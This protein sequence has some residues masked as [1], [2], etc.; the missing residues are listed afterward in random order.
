[1][2]GPP[3]DLPVE[4]SLD[5][6]EESSSL[7]VSVPPGTTT[8]PLLESVSPQLDPTS[9][10]TTVGELSPI[11]VMRAMHESSN[12]ELH[13]HEMKTMEIGSG[14]VNS[15]NC[16]ALD[17]LSWS[18]VTVEVL[19]S[20]EVRYHGVLAWCAVW[21]PGVYE[22][23]GVGLGRPNMERTRLA[24]M[25]ASSLRNRPL[26]FVGATA[27]VAFLLVWP[28]FPK[29]WPIVSTSSPAAKKPNTSPPTEISTSQESFV[30]TGLADDQTAMVY[31][32]MR[33]KGKWGDKVFLEHEYCIQGYWE[34]LVGK[35]ENVSRNYAGL[36]KKVRRLR[37]RHAEMVTESYSARW[38]AYLE[39]A[40]YR[41]DAGKRPCITHFTGCQPCSG[42]HNSMYSGES[43]WKGIERALNFADNQ[44]IRN[45]G[46]VHPGLLDS[47]DL[48]PLPFDFPAE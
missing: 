35:L 18:H 3:V 48:S 8:P 21:G 6:S 20:E 32:L 41:K 2:A 33:E 46:F 24:I 39:A 4:S 23:L 34:G 12:G 5:T 19:C 26:L 42:D 28:F 44:V 7:D 1:M 30:G 10:S 17:G 27:T 14:F 25:M 47:S 36:E 37:R 31:L 43:C 11:H 9:D 45:Y 38:E 15:K 13:V 16:V 40:G 22:L 29:P